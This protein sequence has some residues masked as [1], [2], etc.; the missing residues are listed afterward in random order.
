[1]LKMISTGIAQK[2]SPNQEIAGMPIYLKM[3]LPVRGLK[4]PTKA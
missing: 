4:Q 3:R 2:V 1:M